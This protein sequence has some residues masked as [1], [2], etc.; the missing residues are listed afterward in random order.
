M[1]DFGNYGHGGFGLDSG[2]GGFNADASGGGFNEEGAGSS[3]DRQQV[4]SS[5]T[6]VTIKQ[7]DDATQDAPD[8]EFKVNNVLLNMVSFIGI[9][10]KVDATSS[11]VTLTVEDGTGSIEVRRWIDAAVSSAAEEAEHYEAYLSKYVFVGASVKEFNQKKTLQNA[12][13]YPITD[14]NQLLYH[15]LNAISHHLKSQGAIFNPKAAPQQL[16]FVAEEKPAAGLMKERVLDVL[17]EVSMSM[18][19]GVP[20]SYITQRLNITDEMGEE[21][22]QK[23]L[24]EGKIYNGVDDGSY[25]LLDG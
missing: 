21:C 23:L 17:K 6:P 3:S 15:N 25:M 5:L 1:S 18:Q 4:R 24:E 22:C 9:L 8:E 20:V 7:I 10:R 2:A 11:L 14:H 13:I 19:E 16:L 12:T